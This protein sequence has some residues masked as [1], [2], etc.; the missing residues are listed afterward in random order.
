M[1]I[2]FGVFSAAGAGESNSF[3]LISTTILANSSTT[4][5]SFDVSSLGST[6]K[7]LQARVT[8]RDTSTS[9]GS[10]GL[11]FWANSDVGYNYAWHRLKGG[12]STVI[13][14]GQSSTTRILA[15]VGGRNGDTANIFGTT[16]FDI[17]DFASTTKY[18]TTRGLSGN[19][20]TGG[21]VNTEIELTSGVWQSTS[22]ITS[23]NFVSD[24]YLV[25]GTRLS[26]YGIK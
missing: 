6:Y 16:V 10:S 14:E 12:N 2:P 15:G 11:W 4:S 24:N 13:S 9:A 7:H 5:V 18:K 3:E 21:A 20:G 17:L 26:L 23:V 22:A 1:L 19:V 25:T 8:L